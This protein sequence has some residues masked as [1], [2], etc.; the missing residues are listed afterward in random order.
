M[1][2]EEFGRRSSIPVLYTR[3]TH[4][5]VGIDIVSSRSSVFALRIFHP[6][7]LTQGR[8]FRSSIESHVAHNAHLNNVLV[9]KYQSARVRRIYENTLSA[10]TKSFPQYVDELQGM[11]QGAKVPFFKLFLLHI[12]AI[13]SSLC[14]KEPHG[15]LIGSTTVCC[16][17]ENKA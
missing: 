13:V 14:G 8:T 1:S 4:F 7:F 3:G 6:R 5:D 2:S 11:A 9:E 12:D 16:D 17:Q 10:V 15:G